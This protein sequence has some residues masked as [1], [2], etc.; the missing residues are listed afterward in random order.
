MENSSQM[1]IELDKIQS[2]K[3]VFE[4][5]VNAYKNNLVKEL[6]RT[7]ITSASYYNKP[8]KI[9]KPFKM[10]ISEWWSNF[11]ERLLIALGRRYD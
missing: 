11:I 3:A 10:V 5:Q 4:A 8:V 7:T 2:D 9:K 6:K 1:T